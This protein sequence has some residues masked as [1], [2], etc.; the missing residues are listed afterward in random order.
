MGPTSSST[1]RDEKHSHEVD[2]PTKSVVFRVNGLPAGPTEDDTVA[3][4]RRVIDDN[5]SEDERQSSNS[6]VRVV[7][8]CYEDGRTWVALVE[9]KSGIP[10][11]LS[12]LI[13]NPLGGWEAEI[14]DIDIAFDQHFHGFTQLYA[15]RPGHAVTAE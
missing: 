4:L 6:I 11:F 7:P 2:S 1:A 12:D 8:S 15:T 10:N 5:L 14:E 9:F 13:A 3:L